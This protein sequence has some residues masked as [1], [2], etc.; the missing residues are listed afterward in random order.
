[1]VKTVIYSQWEPR[2]YC[3]VFSADGDEKLQR[4]ACRVSHANHPLQPSDNANFV[5]QTQNV[6]KNKINILTQGD[7]EQQEPT[8]IQTLE[9]V[10]SSHDLWA[11]PATLGS[12]RE[13]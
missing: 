1:M 12:T 7:N 4:S 6:K 8:T 13:H 9:N 2:L 3:R 5:E 11:N 10:L